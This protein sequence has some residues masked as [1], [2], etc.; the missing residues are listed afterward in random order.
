MYYLIEIW[1]NGKCETA[2]ALTKSRGKEIAEEFHKNYMAE[3]TAAGL[4]QDID[5]RIH[6]CV[7]LITFTPKD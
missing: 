6:Q 3:T 4:V 2:H 7:Q 1:A 5:I